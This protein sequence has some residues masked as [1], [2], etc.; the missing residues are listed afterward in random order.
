M[1]GEVNAITLQQTNETQ[2]RQLNE[3]TLSGSK[4][5]LQ[6]GMKHTKQLTTW[7]KFWSRKATLSLSWHGQYGSTPPRL[8]VLAFELL[9][10]AA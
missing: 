10:V 5:R 7:R 9:V 4:T 6:L 2:A 3:I 8:V 1:T